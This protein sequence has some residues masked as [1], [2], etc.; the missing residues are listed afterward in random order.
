MRNSE[1]ALPVCLV[2]NKSENRC[3]HCLLFRVRFSV[4]SFKNYYFSPLKGS[5]HWCLCWTIS[6]YLKQYF[7]FYQKK[8]NFHFLVQHSMPCGHYRWVPLNFTDRGDI[9][10]FQIVVT[11]DLYIFIDLRS[12]HTS[13]NICI[14]VC[15]CVKLQLVYE[16][17][18]SNAKN[19]FYTHSLHLTQC[20]HWHNVII[21]MQTHTQTQMLMLMWMDLYLSIV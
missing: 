17:V 7:F 12:I 21:L 18:V 5:T 2:W 13:V 9:T 10:W 15:V 16:D 4:L 19:G 8:Y 14:C 11:N 1:V 6:I 20:L 3:C